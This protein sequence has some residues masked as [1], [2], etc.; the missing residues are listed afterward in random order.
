MRLIGGQLG[1]RFRLLGGIA[2]LVP[3]GPP[4]TIV[5]PL[6]D[7]TNTVG[8]G[9]WVIPYGGLYSD[10]TS[11]TLFDVPADS[12]ITIDT[13]A[14]E[15]T[16]PDQQILGLVTLR[17]ANA[18]G[19][20]F[21]EMNVDT[22]I[23]NAAP[24]IV[25]NALSVSVP[26]GTAGAGAA[27]SNTVAPAISGTATVGQTLTT[28]DGTWA[29]DPTIAFTYQ[30]Q[31]SDDGAT[32]WANITGATANTY[33]LVS[34]DATK[35]V[36]SVVTATNGAGSASANSAASAQIAASGGTITIVAETGFGSTGGTATVDLSGFG[37][38]QNDLVVIGGG[39]A[40]SGSQAISMVTAG[41]S[42][43]DSTIQTGGVN[44]TNFGAFMKFMGATP[45][46]SVTID[47]GSNVTNGGAGRILILRGVNTTTPLDVAAVPA[48]DVGGNLA[49]PAAITPQTANALIAAFLAGANDNTVTA[50]TGPANM[51]TFGHSSGGGNSRRLQVGVATQVWGGSG[52]FDPDPWT[53]TDNDA[54]DSW[55][56]LSIAFRPA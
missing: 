8:N 39:R 48:S 34:G 5:T 53:G 21:D 30:W 10:Y 55:G 44:K 46:T 33:T 16:V 50:A 43:I 54:D 32:G 15:I 2:P 40:F 11:V 14:E 35:Y 23:P 4:P 25:L 28:T 18:G 56:A 45:D 1:P 29:G 22:S 3:S 49:N 47:V 51:A 36:R 27:P 17:I 9:P 26:E 24:A 6:A 37:L 13:I 52:A 42:Q 12:N 31:R 20:I 41:Y 38:Q 19:A 7:L